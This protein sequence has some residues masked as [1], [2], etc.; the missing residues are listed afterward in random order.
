M[1]W[2]IINKIINAEKLSTEEEKEFD[3]LQKKFVSDETREGIAVVISNIKKGQAAKFLEKISQDA[4]HEQDKQIKAYLI[5][6]IKNESYKHFNN[7]KSVP[8]T[9]VN[10]DGEEYEDYDIIRQEDDTNFTLYANTIREAAE[11]AFK[12][13]VDYVQKKDGRQGKLKLINF[14]TDEHLLTEGDIARNFA[15]FLPWRGEALKNTTLYTIEKYIEYVK[16][17][18]A[19][20]LVL[21]KSSEDDRIK[22]I[23]TAANSELALATDGKPTADDI[24]TFCSLFKLLASIVFFKRK[25]EILE[26]I[27]FEEYATCYFSDEVSK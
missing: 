23:W 4:A 19:D 6:A 20:K 12:A 8:I 7:I 17:K 18:T 3:V 26:E 9:K 15:L 25:P 2:N 22:K 1:W 5:R 11:K 21:N 24:K 14:E 13:A 27:S 10:E 16:D